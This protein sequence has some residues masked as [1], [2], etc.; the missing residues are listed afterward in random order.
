MQHFLLLIYYNL[1]LKSLISNCMRTEKRSLK[2][3]IG[4]IFFKMRV[5]SGQRYDN[6]SRTIILSHSIRYIMNR[7]FI[8]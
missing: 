3:H 8:G 4:M 6:I 7:L 1:L 5:I 2:L